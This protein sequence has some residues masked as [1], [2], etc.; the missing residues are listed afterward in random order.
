VFSNRVRGSAALVAMA[1]IGLVPACAN[2]TAQEADGS[3]ASTADQPRDAHPTTSSPS[4]PS[5]PPP[6]GRGAPRASARALGGRLVVLDPGHNPGNRNHPSEI[7][8]LVDIGTGRKECDTTGTSTDRGYSEAAYTLDVVRRARTILTARGARVKLTQNGDRAYGPCIDQRAR[9]GNTAHA[10]AVVSVHAD[11]A[12]PGDRGFHVI[13]PAAV[14]QGIA[15]NRAVVAP[16][17]RLGGD[18]EKRFAADTGARPANYIAGGSGLDV[19]DDLGGLNLTKVPKVLIECGNMR[20]ADD[21]ALLTAPAWRQKAAL[22][23]ADGITEFLGR[24]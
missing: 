11:G 3:P 13:L 15:D 17:R 1:V 18:L 7:N 20:D 16:S 2:G 19:R 12:P 5:S 22:G 6:R 21:A 8:R 9:I 4:S 24:K 23:I 14:H 10:D